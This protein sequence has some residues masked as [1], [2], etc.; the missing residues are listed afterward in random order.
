MPDDKSYSGRL[1]RFVASP[2]V[3][4]RASSILV[5]LLMAGHLSAYPWTAGHGI[6]ETQLVDSMKSVDFE[7]L[8]ARSTY[9][10][11]YFGWGILISIQLLT[12]SLILWLLSDLV[13]LAPRRL[14]FI[15]GII[16]ACCLVGA[17]L[18]Y[19]YF[20]IPPFLFYLAIW[21]MLLTVSVRL[22]RPSTA[23][24]EERARNS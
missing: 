14:G 9:W 13:R 23:L 17:Y 4:I 10:N 11:L 19:R 15:T 20:Y 24:T 2:V 8:G 1:L 16:S 7:F 3:L 22:L 6:Q 12:L 18:S 21:I 5:V